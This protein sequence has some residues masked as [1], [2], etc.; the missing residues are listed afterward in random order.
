MQDISVSRLTDRA[1]S[2]PAAFARWVEI[3]PG[4][5]A[6]E[7]DERRLT[8]AELDAESNRLARRLAALGMRR[9][10]TV[11][12][13]AQRGLET[14]VAALGTMK[15]GGAYVPLDP[16]S[17]ALRTRWQLRDARARVIVA[18]VSLADR[19]RG[20]GVPI[21]S[22]DREMRALASE[23]PG[24]FGVD[25]AS[26]DLF[27]VLFT[28]GSS[29]RAKGVALEHR[30][31]LNV[32]LGAPEM[33]PEPQEGALHV[34]AP[35][36][37]MAAYEIWATLLSGGRLS[38]HTPGRPDPRA[39]CRTIAE[40]ELTWS[41]MPTSIFHQLAESGPGD[42]ARLRMLLVGGEAMVAR[43]ARRFRD[44]CPDTRLFNIYGPAE[45]TVFIAAHEVGEEIYTEDSVPVGR[46]VAGARAKILDEQGKPVGRGERGELYIAG[47]GVSR[48]YLHQ[49]ELT[50]QRYTIDPSAD[51]PSARVYRSGDLVR[52]RDD[53]VL[54]IFGRTDEQVKVSGYRVEPADVEAQLTAHPRVSQAVVVARE[55]V[56]GHRRLV[57]Y[58]VSAHGELE[59]S[60]LR[61]FLEERLP[62]YMVPSA[63][64]VVERLPINT[65][66]KVD[67]AALPAPSSLRSTAP[68]EPD[69]SGSLAANVAGVFEEVLEVADVGTGEDFF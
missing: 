46:T 34:C 23:D 47:P 9:G 67:R 11:G 21:V 66:G 13:M 42:L 6:V 49:P 16:D 8:Y 59:E 62:P 56:P 38:C 55:D 15:A 53:G 2:I 30:N 1:Q 22:L 61:A 17:P 43:Y 25:V 26:E 57:A 40:R 54:E 68:V 27:A 52:E 35:Q 7:A 39:V 19:V 20:A 64:A 3:Q 12:V 5:T 28:S 4:A 41:T 37:D 48:G 18:P 36:F 33:T 29:G 51:T 31:F 50:A 24:E 69:S 65:N 10:D 58:V 44:A 63:I 14:V 60:A 45:T 32:L